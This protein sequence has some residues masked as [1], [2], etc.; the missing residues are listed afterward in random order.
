[1]K[2]LNTTAII[3]F[4]GAGLMAQAPAQSYADQFQAIQPELDKLIASMDYKEVIEKIGAILPSATPAFTKDPQNPGVGM[5]SYQ[6]LVSIQSFHV[7]LGRAYV[8]LGD[9]EKAISNFNKAEEI[10]N[11]NAV[12]IEDVL[13]PL[14]AQWSA[15]ADNSKQQLEQR[16]E[17]IKLKEQFE[18]VKKEIEAKRRQNNDDKQRLAKIAEN[19]LKL[20]EYFNNVPVWE[21]NLERAPAMVEQLNGFISVSKEDTTKFSPVIKGLEEDLQAEKDLIESKFGGD[22]ARYVTSVVETKENL[23]NLQSQADKVKFLNRLLFLDTKNAAAQKQLDILLGKAAP[24]PEP[25]PTPA[26]RRPPTRR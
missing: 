9:T 13:T 16:D 15:A 6:E 19:E 12:E 8:M 23:D 24:E 5:N 26:P 2:F 18:G 4:A 10:A 3:A 22:K 17:V 25:A 11:T 20:Q 14:I 21:A 7:Y 1:M